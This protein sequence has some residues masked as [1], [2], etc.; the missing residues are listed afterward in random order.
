MDNGGVVKRSRVAGFNDFAAFAAEMAKYGINVNVV[1]VSYHYMDLLA[2]FKSMEVEV[3]GVH[4]GKG[5]ART[6]KM[7]VLE[8]EFIIH[9][10]MLRVS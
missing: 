8:G 10:L 7:R 1:N 5:V 6:A 2:N 4:D 9:D 3:F